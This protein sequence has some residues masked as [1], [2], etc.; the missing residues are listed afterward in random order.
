MKAHVTQAYIA[1]ALHFRG[2][3]PS[4]TPGGLAGTHTAHILT[5]VCVPDAII[6]RRLAV[7]CHEAPKAVVAHLC[8]LYPAAVHVHTVS[9]RDLLRDAILRGRGAESASNVSCVLKCQACSWALLLNKTAT[10]PLQMPGAEKARRGWAQWASS[11]RKASVECKPTSRSSNSMN[12]GPF[13][14]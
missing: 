11:G 3:R 6:A 4:A 1:P 9:V 8:T 5:D 13:C 10:T 7:C 2:F 14:H 12:T